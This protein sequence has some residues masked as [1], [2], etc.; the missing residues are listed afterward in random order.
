[1]ALE[2]T[3]PNEK[4]EAKSSVSADK[5]QADV[6][7]SERSI[8]PAGRADLASKEDALFKSGNDAFAKPLKSAPAKSGNADRASSGKSEPAVIDL[9]VTIEHAKPGAGNKHASKTDVSKDAQGKT[10]TQ[11]Q[12]DEQGKPDAQAKLDA[13]AKPAKPDATPNSAPQKTDGEALV[14]SAKQYWED[15]AKRAKSAGGLTGASSFAAAKI[16]GLGADA[17]IAGHRAYTKVFSDGA[18]EPARS[19]WQDVALNGAME[20]GVVGSTKQAVGATADALLQVNGFGNVESGLSK[21]AK[22]LNQGGPE[23]QL[24]QDLKALGIDST[25]AALTFVPGV[26][27]LKAISRGDTLFRTAAAGTE[28]TGMAATEAR[29]ASSVGTK[30]N[31]A[32]AETLPAG[33]KV[34][35]AAIQNFVGRL[36]KVASEYGINFK[37]GGIIGESNGTINTIEF[38]TKAGGKHEVAHVSHQLQTRATAL[39]AE[40]AKHGKSV[41][42]LTQAERTAAYESIVKPFE[43]VAYNQHEMFAGAAHAWGRTAKNYAEV[44]KANV[45]SF[46]RALST[47]TVPEAKVGLGSQLYGRLP[48]LLGRSQMEIGKNLLSPKAAFLNSGYDRWKDYI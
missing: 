3:A 7:H 23:E 39:E 41:Q 16:M 31:T 33:E 17:A 30:I 47:A 8:K 12:R 32:I 28:I 2:N 27:G 25:L 4:A 14:D 22:G 13:Q 9:S 20:G 29:L 44:L 6:Q 5:L 19:F 34:S 42:E 10:E 15:Q 45:S 26:T 1:M 46:E 11:V 24:G 48:D 36:E 21:V 35:K 43:N 40:A 37:K 38:S 18:I